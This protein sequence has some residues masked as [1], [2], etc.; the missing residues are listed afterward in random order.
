[1]VKTVRIFRSTNISLLAKEQYTEASTSC[2]SEAMAAGEH[3]RRQTQSNEL[4]DAHRGPATVVPMAVTSR[5]TI[6][7]YGRQTKYQIRGHQ[8]SSGEILHPTAYSHVTSG[9]PLIKVTRVIRRK[10][11]PAGSNRLDEL[12]VKVANRK[13]LDRNLSSRLSGTDSTSE[14]HN[15]AALTLSWEMSSCRHNLSTPTCYWK[16]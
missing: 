6:P 9:F 16:T 11:I 14:G 12:F 13:R 3:E 2:R 8:P 10:V 7:A 4:E 5:S 1:M 15:H